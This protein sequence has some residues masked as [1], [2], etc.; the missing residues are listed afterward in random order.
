MGSAWGPLINVVVSASGP[1][2][3]ALQEAGQP[4]PPAVVAKLVVDTGTSPTSIDCTILQQ[5]GLTPT[6]VVP[7]HT[8]STQGQPHSAN[9]FDV[10][11]TILGLVP[12]SVVFH[13]PA[14]PVVDGHFKAQGIDGL[15]GR[16]ILAMARLVYGGPDN[17]YGIS[18]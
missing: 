4:L 2:L 17:W 14:H 15:L 10:G 6:G 8:P 16:D 5:L 12:N 13:S 1:R 7:I 3:V 18:F 9:Q 11:L